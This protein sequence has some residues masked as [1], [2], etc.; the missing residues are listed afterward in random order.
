MGDLYVNNIRLCNGG[1][2][3]GININ[4]LLSQEVNTTS[5]VMFKNIK[6][7][8]TINPMKML[9][10]PIHKYNRTSVKDPKPGFMV[11]NTIG[12]YVEVYTGKEWKRLAW[13]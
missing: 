9:A 12:G 2:I 13:V 6:V 7:L 8:D 3:N 11:Y 10:L 1:T 5:N 4:R